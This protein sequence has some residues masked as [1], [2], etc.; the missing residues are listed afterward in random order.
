[1]TVENTSMSRSTG[2]AGAEEPSGAAVADDPARLE[3]DPRWKVARRVAA[4]KGFA[5]SKFLIS[6]ILYICEKHLL[7]QTS[8]ITEQQIGEHV[9]R[10]PQGYNPGDD[11]IVRNYARLLRQ[12]LDEYF[13]GEGIEETIRIVVPRGGYVPLFVEEDKVVGERNP[14]P[15]LAESIDVAPSKLPE[16]LAGPDWND[17]IDSDRHR[18]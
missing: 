11:N 8:E 15:E 6:F 2:F 1:M 4:S 10:R 12:R 3:E 7:D 5:K 17:P 16:R 18:P 14:E 9:F 13:T